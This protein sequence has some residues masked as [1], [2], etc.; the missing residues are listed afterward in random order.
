VTCLRLMLNE[1][2]MLTGLFGGTV[3]SEVI[4]GE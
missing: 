1:M 4:C 2:L 3:E